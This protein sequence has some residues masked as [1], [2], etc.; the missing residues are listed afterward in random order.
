MLR[1]MS[2]AMNEWAAS[3][4]ATLAARNSPSRTPSAWPAARCLA[5]CSE[6][7]AQCPVCPWAQWSLIAH[8]FRR[9]GE[10]ANDVCG[11]VAWVHG[12]RKAHVQQDAGRLLQRRRPHAGVTGVDGLGV[13]VC[14]VRLSANREGLQQVA[15]VD[16]NPL[17]YAG[18]ALG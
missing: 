11:E 16:T 2:L 10:G 4:S 5:Y 14:R 8:R 6:H 1:M 12:L 3:A 13:E 18:V 9:R 15:P 17:A 7:G